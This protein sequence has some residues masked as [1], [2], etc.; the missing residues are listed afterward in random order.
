MESYPEKCS[1]GVSTYTNE[2]IVEE[3][4]DEFAEPVVKEEE[5]K[6]D[7]LCGW[8]DESDVIIQV[9]LPDD[10]KGPTSYIA[11]F[12]HS[13]DGSATARANLSRIARRQCDYRVGF[14]V[15]EL[16]EITG[17]EVY[18]AGFDDDERKKL[19]NEPVNVTFTE[20]TPDGGSVIMVNVQI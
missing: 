14:T 3:G 5:K 9:K 18:V 17:A 1:D 10:T 16:K 2:V 6:E 11:G 15:D 12:L 7:K 4:P 19:E 20:G 13:I 8:I